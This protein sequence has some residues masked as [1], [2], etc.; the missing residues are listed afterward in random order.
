MTRNEL[1]NMNKA[2]VAN[3]AK[4]FGVKRYKGKSML[5]KT[6][7]IDNICKYLEEQDDIKDVKKAIDEFASDE[8]KNEAASKMER[9]EAAP[10]GVLVAFYEPESGKLNT[11]KMTNR[12]RKRKQIK[13]ETKYG[14]EFIVPFENIAWVKTG[15][16]WPRAIYEEL[17]GMVKS[18]EKKK[19]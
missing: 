6:E 3:I 17:K 7:L 8:N 19:V 4:D 10:I 2:E 14:K 9:I 12:S 1:E 13:C 18:N 15:G 11:A 16:R 5:T